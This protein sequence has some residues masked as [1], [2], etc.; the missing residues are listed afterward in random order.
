M[1]NDQG[2]PIIEIIEQPPLF[3]TSSTKRKAPPPISLTSRRTEK[4]RG[5]ARKRAFEEAEREE[6]V[7]LEK[8]RK[9]AKI[10]ERK[11]KTDEEGKKG[12]MKRLK[13][14]DGKD[15]SLDRLSPIAQKVQSRRADFTLIIPVLSDPRRPRSSSHRDHRT[16]RRLSSTRRHRFL[17]LPRR[18]T[19]TPIY[20]RKRG[21]SS[22]DPS[23]R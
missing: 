21:H 9:K 19:S 23:R 1:T 7:A 6:R 14:E 13:G 2:L 17:L 16:R 12:E 8:E 11:K 18:T 22:T 3:P 10:L 4:Q 15:V 5:E 20:I